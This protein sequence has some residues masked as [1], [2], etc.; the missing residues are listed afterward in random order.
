ME[1]IT[2]RTKADV[3]LGTEKGTY[4]AS[5]LNRVE[6]A[7]AELAERLTRAGMEYTPTVITNWQVG[8]IPSQ[9]QMTRYLGNVFRLCQ[10]AGMAPQLPVSMDNLT[11]DGAN[12]IELALL[13]VYEKITQEETAILLIS[14][15]GLVLRDSVGMYLDSKDNK[16]CFVVIG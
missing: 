3:L 11:W 1:L 6:S 8:E 15:D 7:V 5:D 16:Q 4:G 13:A 10:L 14:A 2:D 9:T 12:Q